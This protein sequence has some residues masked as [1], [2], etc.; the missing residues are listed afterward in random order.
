[1]IPGLNGGFTRDL[2]RLRLVTSRMLVSYITLAVAA[3][4]KNGA[5]LSC[6]RAAC[7]ADAREA[8]AAPASPALRSITTAALSKTSE[9]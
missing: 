1:M 2:L 4:H 3:A 7:V 8:L 6:T 5:K 9:R